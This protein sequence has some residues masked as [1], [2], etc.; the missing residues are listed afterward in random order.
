[1]KDLSKHEFLIDFVWDGGGLW[2]GTPELSTD[3]QVILKTR[4]KKLN[5]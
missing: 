2:A 3:S 1:M 4:K 5:Y